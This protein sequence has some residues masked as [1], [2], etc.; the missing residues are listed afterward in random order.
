MKRIFKYLCSCNGSLTS[1]K[2]KFGAFFVGYG[3]AKVI[4]Y[5]FPNFLLF[6]LYFFLATT[7]EIII[8]SLLRKTFKR[9][10]KKK[11]E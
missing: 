1:K 10:F 7:A 6:L 11:I 3:T 4:H 2:E 9:I 8:W 5:F